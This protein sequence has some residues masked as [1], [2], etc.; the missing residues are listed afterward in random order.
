MTQE[1]DWVYISPLVGK[2]VVAGKTLGVT[3]AIDLV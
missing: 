3:W 2:L 1:H